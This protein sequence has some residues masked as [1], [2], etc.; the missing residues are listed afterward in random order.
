MVWV[1]TLSFRFIRV[2][3]AGLTP[4]FLMRAYWLTPFRYRLST[5]EG[6]RI[7]AQRRAGEGKH[8]EIKRKKDHNE[9]IP[10]D[11]Y[12][13]SAVPDPLRLRRKPA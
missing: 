2:I 12:R 9:K 3:R 6:R 13:A 5:E 8:R 1:L 11:F 4:C 10:V 7:P